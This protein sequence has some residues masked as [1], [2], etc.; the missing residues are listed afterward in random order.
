MGADGV[1]VESVVLDVGGQVD[2]VGDLLQE[3][4]LAFQGAEAAFPG[5][6]LPGAL[7]PGSDVAQ[8]GVGRDERLEPAAIGTGRR[9][10]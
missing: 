10:P 5:A 1:V 2:R 9:C 8:L 4:P 3:E 7:D 6:V